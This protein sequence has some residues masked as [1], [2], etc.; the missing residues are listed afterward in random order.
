MESVIHWRLMFRVGDRTAFDKCVAQALAAV[1]PGCKAGEG[2]PYWK[3]HE[4]WECSALSP[5]PEGRVADQVL[6]CLLAAQ[7]LA[8]GWHITGSLAPDAAIGFGGVFAAGHAGAFSRVAGLEWASFELAGG[9]D[10]EQSVVP[11]GD[12]L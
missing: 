4:L 1:G 8:S 2:Q 12:R 5:A 10:A 6:G 7:R 11:A 3:T 9:P